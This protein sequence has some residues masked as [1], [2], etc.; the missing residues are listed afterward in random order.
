MERSIFAALIGGLLGITALGG[1]AFVGSA[2][3]SPSALPSR[4]EGEWRLLDPVVYE[5]ISIFPVVSSQGQDTSPF[6]TLEEGLATGEVTVAEQGAQILQRS[7]DGRPIYPPQYNTGASVN[8]LVLINRSRRPLLLLAG[9]L[10]SG[11]KQDRV[12]GKD[13]IVP[14]GAP[15]LPLDV[16]CVEHGRWTGA[17]QFAAANTIVHPSVRERAAVDQKQAEVWDAVRSGTTARSAP[18]DPRPQ[19]SSE[20]LQAAIAGNGRTE[21]YEKIYVSQ[22]VGVS[23]DD[24]VNEVQRRFV[25]ATSGLKNERVVGVVVAYG[26]EV[27]WSDIFASG[28]LFD[29]YWR[30]LLRSY[31]VEALTRPTYRQ[32]ASRDNAAEF[33]RRLNGRETQ[34]TEP[35]VYRWREI[36]E[37]QLAQIEL[38][39][40]QP[41]P[42]T[43]HRLLLHRTS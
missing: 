12:I 36:K 33:L 29:H 28:D 27:A 13:R 8:Q 11:G 39:A 41:K 20:N 24:F 21:A 15:P 10:V 6:L 7:R 3:G 26:G 17:A 25:Q 4:P 19:I 14:V 1:L 16:F 42:I 5:N 37:G 43:L 38:D 34:E 40:L 18:S 35:G 30:K 9:E 23:I 32:A 31:A 22:A 2:P